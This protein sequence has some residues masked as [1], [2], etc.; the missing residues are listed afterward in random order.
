MLSV[1]TWQCKFDEWYLTCGGLK[2]IK[3]GWIRLPDQPF[4]RSKKGCRTWRGT[5]SIYSFR[6]ESVAAH[7][8]TKTPEFHQLI[9]RLRTL[10]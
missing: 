3:T 5:H 4:S 8:E 1:D 9:L 10:T 7:E 2:A 6:P